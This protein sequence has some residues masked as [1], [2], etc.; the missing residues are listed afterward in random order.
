M[1]KLLALLLSIVMVMAF[2]TGCGS[3]TASEGE[4]FTANEGGVE[5]TPAQQISC[6]TWSNADMSLYIRV[7]SSKTYQFFDKDCNTDGKLYFWD[8]L[9]G[10]DDTIVLHNEFG[11]E[12][13]TLTFG[14]SEEECFC[15]D[16]DGNEYPICNDAMN[17]T[18]NA[19]IN[20]SSL[21]DGQLEIFAH[22]GY[23]L[24]N[25]QVEDLKEGSVINNT[26]MG[27]MEIKVESIEKKEDGYYVINGNMDLTQTDDG[28]FW[29]LSGGEADDATQID[30]VGYAAIDEDTEFVDTLDNGAHA[31][32]EECIKANEYVGAF[33][34][35]ENFKVKKIEVLEKK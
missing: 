15:T 30:S 7:N 16:G 33:V 28:S 12:E 18:Y 35:V 8:Y 13:M 25:W 3:N 23:Y 31:S 20:Q 14:G 32:I 17:G 34:T 24:S 27:Y 9:E 10:S 19:D 4:E 5:M 1:K 2:A 21:E 29:I 6:H 26:D 11:G 22:Q